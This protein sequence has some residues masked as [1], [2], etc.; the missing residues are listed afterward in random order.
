MLD[1]IKLG[2]DYLD[3]ISQG[4]DT[5]N[6]EERAAYKKKHHT[7]VKSV[8]VRPSNASLIVPVSSEYITTDELWEVRNQD[9]T[10]I[11]DKNQS[12]CKWGALNSKAR[13]D[14]TYRLN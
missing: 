11:W 14:Q 4:L 13:Q 10:P 2:K 6:D 7:D 5:L 3:S 8:R 12:V 9:L 1:H